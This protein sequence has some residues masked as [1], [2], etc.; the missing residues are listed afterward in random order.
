MKDSAAIDGV[1]S[2]TLSNVE[3]CCMFND[4]LYVQ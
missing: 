1:V 3:G 2:V 4:G